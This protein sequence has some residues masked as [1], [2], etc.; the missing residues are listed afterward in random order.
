[1][2]IEYSA[3]TDRSLCNEGVARIKHYIQSHSVFKVV[4]DAALEFG[5]DVLPED[6]FTTPLET[7]TVKLQPSQ[8]YLAFHA[9]G[10]TERESLIRCIVDALA[11]E[12]FVCRFEEL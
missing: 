12:G 3:T 1:M 2:S 4:R 11:Q 7:I 9:C 10:R 8:V 6:R 5:L